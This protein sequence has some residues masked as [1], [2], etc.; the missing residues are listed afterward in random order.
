MALGSVTIGG[1]YG[2]TGCTVSAAGVLQCD[3]AGTFGGAVVDGKLNLDDVTYTS[4]GAQNLTPTDSMYELNP[5]SVLTITLQTGS[6]AKGDI[7]VLINIAAVNV[8]I[9][10]TNVKTSDGGLVTL[11]QDDAIMFIFMGSH[12]YEVA[13]SPNS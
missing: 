3:G 5:A 9:V 2:S 13:H 6:A 10:D 7:L 4:V 8:T 1:G 11:G 12:W